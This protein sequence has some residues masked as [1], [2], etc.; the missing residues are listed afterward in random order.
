MPAPN[1]PG[2]STTFGRL[3]R[4]HRIAKQMSQVELAEKMNTEQQ[5]VSRWEAGKFK[6]RAADWPRLSRVLGIPMEDMTEAVVKQSVAHAKMSDEDRQAEVTK[7]A[8]RLDQVEDDVSSILQ[9]L[10]LMVSQLGLKIPARGSEPT[11]PTRRRGQ[12]QARSPRLA[13]TASPRKRG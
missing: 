8:S 7:A 13:A 3:I 5:T 10:D 9:T 11:A 1:N 4:K 2:A 6:P 12:V